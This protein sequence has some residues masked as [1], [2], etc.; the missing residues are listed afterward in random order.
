MRVW[1]RGYAEL[2]YGDDDETTTISYGSNSDQKHITTYFRKS[3]SLSESDLEADQFI[4]ELVKDDGAIIYLNGREI[5]RSNMSYDAATSQ[6][7]A[8]EPMNGAEESRF[9]YYPLDRTQLQSGENL[10]AVEI[11][12][13]NASSSDLSFNLGLFGLHSRGAPIIDHSKSLALNLSGDLCLTAIYEV[14]GSCMLPELVDSDLRLSVDCS[15]Y[16]APGDVFISESGRLSI[17]PGVEIWMP[18]GASIFVE[19]VIEAI[20]DRRTAHS[21]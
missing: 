2:G 11:H 20:G 16:L 8:L 12:Q 19:G 9:Q 10:L 6:T 14:S 13:Y 18:E 7:L 4:L 1:S 17:D 15:P 5:V 3:F 21:F